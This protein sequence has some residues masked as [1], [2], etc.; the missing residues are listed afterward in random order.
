[1]IL[2]LHYLKK[3]LAMILALHHLKKILLS[4][5]LCYKKKIKI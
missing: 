5:R 2:A 4:V 1:M 3:D